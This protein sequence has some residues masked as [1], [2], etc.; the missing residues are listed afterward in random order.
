[1]GIR[2]LNSFI[3]ECNPIREIN[4]SKLQ[5]LLKQMNVKL[6]FYSLEE[7]Q[8]KMLQQGKEQHTKPT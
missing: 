5:C 2:L 6:K 4:Y 3:L 7:K 1:M 8:T